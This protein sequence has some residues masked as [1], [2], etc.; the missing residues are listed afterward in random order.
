[1]FD[2]YHRSLT[3]RWQSVTDRLTDCQ[4]QVSASLFK[5]LSLKENVTQFTL[6]LQDAKQKLKR[7]SELQPTLQAKKA[8][9]QNIKVML[10]TL[11]TVY[12]HCSA[13]IFFSELTWDGLF[14][15]SVIV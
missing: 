12:S 6:W 14:V 8:V 2:V 9:M 11:L 4:K 5:L 15:S 3:D 1:M 13:F 7:D 10:L